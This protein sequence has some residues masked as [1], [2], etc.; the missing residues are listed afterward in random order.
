M[1]KAFSNLAHFWRDESGAT[2][3]EYGLMMGLIALVV[4]GA[5]TAFGIGV[6]GLFTAQD[7]AIQKALGS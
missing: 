5:V 3:V 6:L 7:N 2:M 4:L 1:S